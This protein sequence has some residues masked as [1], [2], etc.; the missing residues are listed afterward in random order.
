MKR[1]II[2]ILMMLLVPLK[3]LGAED[4]EPLDLFKDNTFI[5]LRG[6]LPLI[7]HNYVF[8]KEGTTREIEMMDYLDGIDEQRRFLGYG[9]MG[10]GGKITN[11]FN[12]YYDEKIKTSPFSWMIIPNIEES[13]PSGII[14]L[15]YSF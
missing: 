11:P 6:Y 2:I 15:T 5:I 13:Q 4:K 8:L 7:P 14:Q 9:S 12:E 10:I 3:Y 1:L